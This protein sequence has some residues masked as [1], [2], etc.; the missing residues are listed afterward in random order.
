LDLPRKTADYA[1]RNPSGLELGRG[2]IG[3]THQQIETPH[4]SGSMKAVFFDLYE[5]L[6][7]HFDPD[8]APPPQSIAQRLGIDERAYA[9]LWRTSDTAWQL[10][11]ISSYTEALARICAGAGREADPAVL[12][13]LT[14]EY[15]QMTARVFETIESEIVEMLAALTGAGL[16]LGVITNAGDLDTAPWFDCRLA[17]YFDDVLASHEVGLLKRDGRIFELAC[18]RLD[19]HPSEALFVGDGGGDELH[20]AT[21]AGLTAYWCTWFLDR[22]PE[23]IRPNGFPGDAWRQYATDREPPFERLTRPSDLLA[24]IVKSI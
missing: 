13:Q 11:E 19:I 3:S 8:W 7:T 1:T 12:A 9:D 5:T 21:Q 24:R 15:Q 4:H 17:P 10:G 14:D 18:R 2:E 16:R 20:G 6:V 22:W 23:G